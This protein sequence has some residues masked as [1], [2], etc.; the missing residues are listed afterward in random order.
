MNWKH[1]LDDSMEQIY[2]FLYHATFHV[3]GSSSPGVPLM[4]SF[5]TN[6]DLFESDTLISLTGDTKNIVT[7]RELV[8]LAATHSVYMMSMYDFE[9]GIDGIKSSASYPVR[10]FVKNEVNKVKKSDENGPT[11]RIIV[12]ESVVTQLATY[13]V[14]CD[15]YPNFKKDLG[16]SSICLGIGFTKAKVLSVVNKFERDRGGRYPAVSNDVSGW[17]QGFSFELFLFVV[18]TYFRCFTNR[19]AKLLRFLINYAV[20]KAD[21]I[22][23]MPNGECVRKKYAGLMPSGILLTAVFNS[24]A[25]FLLS[26]LMGCWGVFMGDDA[27]EYT[28]NPSRAAEEA[29][30]MGV[31]IKKDVQRPDGTWE[32]NIIPLTVDVDNKHILIDGLQFCSATLHTDGLCTPTDSSLVKSLY[33]AIA[34]KGITYTQAVQCNTV[35]CTTDNAF[36]QLL[37]NADRIHK[38]ALRAGIDVEYNPDEVINFGIPLPYVLQD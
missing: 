13:S 11:P 19:N 12:N 3:N 31:N 15:V 21:C 22:Y 34:Y 38:A 18:C 1:R 26:I 23:V 5:K 32:I 20:C 29:E 8:A 4:S 36:N 28:P 33:K 30:K 27:C 16:E 37:A 35:R 24:I 10:S 17:E 7:M 14:Y 25:R 6:N 2:E 9:D